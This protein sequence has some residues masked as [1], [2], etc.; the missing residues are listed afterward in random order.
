MIHK[1][2]PKDCPKR[3]NF[4]ET[5]P[6]R[7]SDLTPCDFFLWCYLKEKVF[8]PPLPPYVDEYKLRIIAAIEIIDRDMLQWVRGE[9][10]YRL[11]ICWDMNGAQIEHL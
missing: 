8:V 10:D 3:K 2:E 11:Y 5:L 4:S 7:S 6:P 9:P 1:L